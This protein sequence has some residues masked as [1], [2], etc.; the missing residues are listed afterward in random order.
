M[1]KSAVYPNPEADKEE[2][3]FV[4][5]IY[6]HKGTFKEA[7]TVEYAYNLN[8]P[9]L[10]AVRGQQQ[11]TLSSSLETVSVDTDN[12]QI[13]VIKKAENG[14]GSIIRLYEFKNK[15]AEAVLTFCNSINEAEEC[16]LLENHIKSLEVQENQVKFTVKPYEIKTIRIKK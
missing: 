2:H 9:L 15:R 8:T 6:P 7:R 14:D 12:I 16:D 10:S 13:E 1:L 4:Y 3:D 11:G 5:S